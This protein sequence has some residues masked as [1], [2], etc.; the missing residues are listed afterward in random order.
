MPVPSAVLPKH[1]E[2]VGCRLK[3][4]TP[5][6]MREPDAIHRQGEAKA[7]LCR[8]VRI[9]Q[10][11]R[12]NPL[13]D[14]EIL[15]EQIRQLTLIDRDKATDEGDV[16]S[17]VDMRLLDPA[18]GGDPALETV[19]LDETDLMAT[20]E[21]QQ[22]ARS[23]ERLNSSVAHSII[24]TSRLRQLLDPETAGDEAQ[25]AY[26]TTIAERPPFAKRHDD[27]G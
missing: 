1:I 10:R 9:A 4:N 16:L 21:F 27:S 23:A 8:P 12:R 17:A 3:C 7:I 24:A 15:T 20:D 13:A 26:D 18:A 5:S 6:A 25:P 22:L 2:Q 14:D 11:R 19:V